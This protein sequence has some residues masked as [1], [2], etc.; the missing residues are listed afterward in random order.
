M[1]GFSDF[2]ARIGKAID[3][4]AGSSSGAGAPAPTTGAADQTQ[5]DWG[6]L[7]DTEQV[8]YETPAYDMREH[9]GARQS[10]AFRAGLVIY[11]DLLGRFGKRDTWVPRT[12]EEYGAAYITGWDSNGDR[13]LKL[14]DEWF[15]LTAHQEVDSG[16]ES[17]RF[18]AEQADAQG[19]RDGWGNEHEIAAIVR[20]YD[21]NGDGTLDKAEN[22][23]FVE[24]MIRAPRR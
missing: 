5:D 22:D 15:G 14:N 3:A 11:Q 10:E 13:A 16:N 23:R 20:T 24:E 9:A 18:L 1:T 2:G 8:V 7:P 19:N 17:I 21:T 6:W 12:P 4:L